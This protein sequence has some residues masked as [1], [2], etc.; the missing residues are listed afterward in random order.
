MLEPFLR[1]LPPRKRKDFAEYLAQ[2]H[3][4]ADFPG[5]DF[6]LL[7]YTSAK[8]PADG[9]SLINDSSVFDRSCELL[10]EVA[11]TRYQE[12]LDL[13]L[14]QVGDPVEFL[15]EPDNPHDRD[16]VAV[17]HAAGRLGY[18]NK[19]HCKVVKNSVKAKKINAFVAKKNGT[20]VRPLIYLLVE[21]D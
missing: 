1:R 20:Q 18:V 7:G 2:H 16:A 13:S 6:A 5:S 8:S 17:I 3:L 15:A 14:V 21:C 12:G 10:L 11:G 4:P 9:F 19:V